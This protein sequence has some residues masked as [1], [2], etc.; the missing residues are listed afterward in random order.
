MNALTKEKVQEVL[1]EIDRLLKESNISLAIYLFGGMGLGLQDTIK[2]PTVDLDF[3]MDY[4]DEQLREQVQELTQGKFGV[5]CDIGVGLRFFLVGKRFA[6]VLPES[7]QKR[8]KELKSLSE[9]LSNLKV[10]VL[11]PLDILIL[12]CDRMEEQ[13]IRD[14]EKILLQHDIPFAELERRFS[15]FYQLLEGDFIS[16]EN[17]RENFTQLIPYFHQVYSEIGEAIRIIEQNFLEQKEFYKW[18]K[19]NQETKAPRLVQAFKQIVSFEKYSEN[20]IEHHSSIASEL[21]KILD[22]YKTGA[23]EELMEISDEQLHQSLIE[24]AGILKNGD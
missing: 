5:H 14:I 10:Y 12:K 8:A 6:W 15:E 17:I 4:N 7:A 21:G 3:F 11:D 13:D 19:V 1:E 18:F 20:L 9:G 2:R 22:E 16:I 23:V 24:I